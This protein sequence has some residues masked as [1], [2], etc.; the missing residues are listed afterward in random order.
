[1]LAAWLAYTTCT[2]RGGY[3]GQY[4]QESL[5]S[6]EGS[7]IFLVKAESLVVVWYP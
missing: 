6:G 3:T 4:P 7:F 5:A 2:P 1:V